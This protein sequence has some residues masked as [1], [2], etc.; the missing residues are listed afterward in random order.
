MAEVVTG[1]S[2]GAVVTPRRPGTVRD[3]CPE[4][5]ICPQSPE[6]RMEEAEEQ[7]KPGS[8]LGRGPEQHVCEV[9]GTLV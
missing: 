8:Q 3:S 7:A 9:T 6:R 1:L 2:G 5:V 4:G